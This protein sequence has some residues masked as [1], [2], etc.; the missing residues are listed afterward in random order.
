MPATLPCPKMPHAPAM[1]RV[2]TP[3]RSTYWFLRK[4]MAAWAIVSR[5]VFMLV[6]SHYWNARVLVSPGCAHPGVIGVVAGG[7]GAGAAG[8]GVQIIDVVPVGRDDRMIPLGDED[9]FA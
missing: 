1:K 3:S 2:S 6:G 8:E 5:M 9:E 4:R 7:H